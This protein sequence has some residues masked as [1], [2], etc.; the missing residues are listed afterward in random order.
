MIILFLRF[1]Y[2]YGQYVQQYHDD[3][4][5]GRTVI[6]V[7]RWDLQAHTNWASKTSNH[8][9]LR[10]TDEK[11]EHSLLDWSFNKTKLR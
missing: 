3:K 5:T 6:T 1:E 11:V 10:K 4:M 7:G 9:V 2:C 8:P